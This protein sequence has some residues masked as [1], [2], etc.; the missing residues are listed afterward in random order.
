MKRQELKTLPRIPPQV[1]FLLELLHVLG[2]NRLR[3]FRKTAAV[4]Q[5]NDRKN[6]GTVRFPDREEVREIVSN[7]FPSQRRVL[8]FFNRSN[9]R[10][11]PRPES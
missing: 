7:T 4:Q 5:R 10:R 1:P 6:L 8:P 9:E 2:P 3:R 11:V